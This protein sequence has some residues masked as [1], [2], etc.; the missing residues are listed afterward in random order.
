MSEHRVQIN[1]EDVERVERR[2]LDGYDTPDEVEVDFDQ[3]IK[4]VASFTVKGTGLLATSAFMSHVDYH[5]LQIQKAL[6]ATGQADIGL[7][8]VSLLGGDPSMAVL[9]ATAG[10][11]K[12]TAEG[13]EYINVAITENKE[14]DKVKCVVTFEADYEKD[15]EFMDDRLVD[16]AR[17]AKVFLTN[18]HADVLEKMA[19]AG[20]L[21]G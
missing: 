19:A 20:E 21:D 15:Q 3:V 8:M 13:N 17:D 2:I 5:S 4:S 14:G 11:V 18:I 12:E 16:E 7:G 6:G 10:L 9:K 1:A